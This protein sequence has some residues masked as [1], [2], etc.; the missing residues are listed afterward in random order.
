MWGKVLTGVA[1]GVGAVAAAPFTGGG[2]LVGGQLYYLHLLE[3]GL[4]R[5]QRELV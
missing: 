4:L 1:V 5:L 2:S 3:Q